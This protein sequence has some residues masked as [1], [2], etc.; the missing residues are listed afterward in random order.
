MKN[1]YFSSF[2]KE[3]ALNIIRNILLESI[4]LK[5]KKVS[6]YDALGY[7]SAKDYASAQTSPPANV[8]AMDGYA[9]YSSDTLQAFDSNP[10]E[11]S[12]FLKVQTG[13]NI[14]QY[15]AVV[16]FEDVQVKD[17]KIIIRQAYNPYQNVRK[18]GEDILI[19]TEIVSKGEYL[20][21]ADL[22]KLKIGG[23]KQLEVYEM[24][25]VL[26][27]PTGNE[28]TD[29]ITTENQLVE[30]NSI[31]F[32]NTLKDYRFDITINEILPN[33]IKV[34]ENVINDNIDNYDIIFVNAGSSKG[35]HD[36]TAKAIS[37]IG[38]VLVHGIAIKPGKPTIIGKVRNKLVMGLPGFP[39]SMFFSLIEV[40][41][42]AF[43]DTFKL[44][45]HYNTLQLR[46][47]R[48]ISSSL[49]AEEYIRVKLTH[50][51]NEVK[52]N[53]LKRGASLIESINEAT[54]YIKIPQYVEYIEAGS[55][56]EIILL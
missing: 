27:I 34:I 8:S 24:P 35:D 20:K 41:L 53:I 11:I 3:D 51:E 22:V 52:C 44:K 32:M 45:K 43:F 4:N 40:F 39:V 16:P 18:K 38:E 33:D 26:F 13:E 10:V 7:F 29:L 46:I 25:K 17:K 19:D 23:Y 47:D 42:P 55:Q 9:I 36:Y 37:N 50:L 21:K 15:N 14:K 28:L 54:G 5:T 1:Y 30:F 48:G 2:N 6:V 12:S 49:E 31:L 56:V